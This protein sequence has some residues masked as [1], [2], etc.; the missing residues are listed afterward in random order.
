MRST[1]YVSFGYRQLRVIRSRLLLVSTGPGWQDH[2]RDEQLC[3]AQDH[4]R[5]LLEGVPLRMQQGLF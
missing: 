2:L 1:R 5:R 4:T 3:R